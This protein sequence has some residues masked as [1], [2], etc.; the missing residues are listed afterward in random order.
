MMNTKLRTLA[1]ATLAATL[2]CGIPAAFAQDTALPNTIVWTT[3]DTGGAMHS[4]AVAISSALKQADDVNLRVISA[5]N[6]L[7][8]QSTLKAGRADFVLA[9]FDVYFAQEG[10][11]EFGAKDWGPQP[12]RLVMTSMTDQ[13]FGLAIAPDLAEN[14]KGPADLRGLRIAYV[15]GSPSIQGALQALVIA[16]G[17]MTWDDV[18]KVE[19]PGFGASVDAYINDQADV[20][21]TSTNS[22]TSVKA[23]ASSRGLA[24]V[25]VPFDN[26]ACWEKITATDPRWIQKVVTEGVN[27]PEGG[28]EMASY[29]DML[30][31]TTAAQDPGYV[32]AMITAIYDNFDNIKGATPTTYGLELERQILD[33]TVPFHDG[34]IAYFKE[35]GVWTDEMQSHNDMLVA[36]QDALKAA[37][38]EVVAMDISDD[39][40]FATAWKAKRIEVLEAQGFD[41]PVRDW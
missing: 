11:F 2:T 10:A 27:I 7:A 18:E 41:V 23:D 15:Q 16:C 1:G 40:E 5:G 3:Y 30:L 26:E 32:K 39:A 13:G 21:F 38:D 36:R 6:G 37:W 20:Y 34:A 29:P 14:V 35:A 12:V 17:D 25:P 22:G 8:Q 24:W 31:N 19:V 33:Y 9:G 4:A 28:I